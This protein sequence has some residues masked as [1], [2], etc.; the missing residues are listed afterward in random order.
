M[1]DGMIR[2]PLSEG[3][4]AALA[5]GV[6]EHGTLAVAA[7]VCVSPATI[8]AALAGHRLN[9]LTVRALESYVASVQAAPHARAA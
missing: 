7:A 2:R 6:R 4:Q 3:S 1:V 8:R 9:P 5:A